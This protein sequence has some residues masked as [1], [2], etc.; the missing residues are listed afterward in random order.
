MEAFRDDLDSGIK[1][2][3]DAMQEYKETGSKIFEIMS[4]SSFEARTQEDKQ[5]ISTLVTKR[6]Q[7]AN[8]LLF[9]H[10]LIK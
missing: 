7:Q 3:F 8:D 1:P 10:G 5:D 2:I 6:N 4:L 9:T